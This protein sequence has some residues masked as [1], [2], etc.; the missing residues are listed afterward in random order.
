[1][2][3]K[4]LDSFRDFIRLKQYAYSTEKSYIY[5]ARK[6][7]LFHDKRHPEEMGAKEIELIQHPYP[8]HTFPLVP[9]NL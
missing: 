1:M 7:I 8:M 9:I 3:K 2:A 5:W 6:F 4:F